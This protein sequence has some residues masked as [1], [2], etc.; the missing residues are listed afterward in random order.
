M[1]SFAKYK[2]A[3]GEFWMIRL[4]LTDPVTLEKN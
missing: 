1:A 2:T 3:N 4:Y